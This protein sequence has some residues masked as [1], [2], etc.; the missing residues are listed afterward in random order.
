VAEVLFTSDATEGH[1]KKL[2]DHASDAVLHTLITAA[3]RVRVAMET[4]TTHQDPDHRGYQDGGP[5]R[6][7][8]VVV[9]NE[10]EGAVD[11]ERTLAPAVAAEAVQSELDLLNL[12][13]KDGW[14]LVNSADWAVRDWRADRGHRAAWLE[15]HRIHLRLD[16]RARWWRVLRRSRP[17]WTVARV[18]DA[19]GG[20]ECGP[21]A[22]RAV[23]DPDSGTRSAMRSRSA[24]SSN[25]SARTGFR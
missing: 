14:L 17:K 23:L 18:R 24:Y 12:P 21:P 1:P 10:H 13:V 11:L 25:V 22:C 20:Q 5:V 19:R 4:L 6:L 7:D 16:G 15:G 3:P 8:A 2:A 9:S